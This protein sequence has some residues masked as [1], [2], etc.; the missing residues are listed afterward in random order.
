VPRWREF[1]AETAH[2]QPGSTRHRGVL[3]GPAK[4]TTPGASTG[5]AAPRAQ[6]A[7]GATVSGMPQAARFGAD[8]LPGSAMIQVN[9]APIGVSGFFGCRHRRVIG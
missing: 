8:I 6:R 5:R 1:T 3:D 4:T 7:S 9:R 2:A